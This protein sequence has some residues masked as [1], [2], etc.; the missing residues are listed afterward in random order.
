M[1]NARTCNWLRLG[2]FFFAATLWSH[3]PARVEAAP[4]CMTIKDVEHINRGSISRVAQFK[5]KDARIFVALDPI[6]SEP[7]FQYEGH[8]DEAFIASV[9]QGRE[10]LAAAGIDELVLWKLKAR[11]GRLGVAVPFKDGCAVSGYGEPD[12]MEKLTLMKETTR[13]ISKRGWDD[14]KV[15]DSIKELLMA[16]RYASFYNDEMVDIMIDRIRPLAQ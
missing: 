11:G 16:S 6:W 14:P 9:K 5:G 13:L 8:R 12:L 10:A 2:L 4:E 7:E 3:S 1:T 15:R